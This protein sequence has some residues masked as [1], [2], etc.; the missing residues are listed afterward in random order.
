MTNYLHTVGKLPE[1][2]IS[3]IEKTEPKDMRFIGV[4]EATEL[5]LL[6]PPAWGGGAPIGKAAETNYR[7]PDVDHT[8]NSSVRQCAHCDLG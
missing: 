2:I 5:G 3:L 6:E 8:G 1:T 7:K 4:T